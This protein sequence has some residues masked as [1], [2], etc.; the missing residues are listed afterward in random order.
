MIFRDY[1]CLFCSLSVSIN[2]REIEMNELYLKR[3]KQLIPQEFDQYIKSLDQPLYQGLRTNPLKISSEKLF[4]RLPFLNRPSP[5][6]SDSWY[7]QGHYGNH[8]AHIC[9]LFYLQ[10]P[11]AAAAVEALNIEKGMNVLDL[12]AAPGSKST[13]IAGKNPD[14]FLVCNEL[15]SSRAQAL[16]SNLERMGTENF[17]CTNM[18]GRDL[19]SQ[20]SGFFDRILVDAPCSGEGMMK[21]HDAARDEWSLENVM[22]CSARQKD[23]LAAAVTALK[24]GGEMVYSTCTYA[25]EENEENVV[26]L[27]NSFSEMEQLPVEGCYGRRG[28]DTEGMDASMVRRIFPM[29]AGEGHFIARFRKKEDAASSGSLKAKTLRPE[30]PDRHVTEFLNQQMGCG[31]ENYHME[32]D[33]RKDIVRVYGMNHPFL[34]LKKGRILRQGVY[35]GDLLKKRFEPA[36]AFFL[37]ETNSRNSMRKADLSLSEMDQFMHGEQL[38]IDQLERRD[39]IR[40]LPSGFISVCHD[41]APFGF[42]KTDGRRITNKIPKGLRLSAAS[43]VMNDQETADLVQ[44]DRKIQGGRT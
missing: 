40:Q 9:G 5:F 6:A 10:E 42:G 18:D 35:L 21:K 43:H 31:Y 34:A 19:C 36:H 44:N 23:L 17:L 4:A 32:K 2:E 3:M 1:F 33:P 39:E 11:S 15:D 29:D 38:N 20:F 37:S 12:C 14:G 16:L 41:G 26:W 27:L 13:Q 25:P 24:P 30:K 8:P 7:I 28:V 22:T